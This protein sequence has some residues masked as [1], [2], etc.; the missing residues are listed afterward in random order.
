MPIDNKPVFNCNGFQRLP[1]D[2]QLRQQL[3][4]A[5][6]GGAVSAILTCPFDVVKTRLQIAPSASHSR[7]TQQVFSGTLD[8]FI[9]IIRN[10]G[11]LTLWRGLAPTLVMTIPNAAIYF[12]TYEALKNQITRIGFPYPTAIPLVSGALARI[13]AVTTLAPLEFIR[14]NSQARHKDRAIL[15]FVR[16]TGVRGL[17]LG[18]GATLSRD[19]PFSAV[20]WTCYEFFKHQIKP[21]M[22]QT[23]TG[24]FLTSFFS[25]AFSGM[26]SAILTTPIDLV[27]TRVQ[28]GGDSK[29]I[30]PKRKPTARDIVRIIYREEG[31]K[32]FMRGW[33]PRASKVGP[34]CAIMISSY[35]IIKTLGTPYDPDCPD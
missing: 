11:I 10:E 24:S 29:S 14:T 25:G 30:G 34:A 12:N 32:G 3:M 7:I 8:A 13:V 5:S 21:A 26:L 4:A 2:V 35:E 6:F 1:Y 28:T 31:M 20:Y 15:S 23:T 33:V 22:P 9:K 27:K 19:V 17:W 18:V 16:K